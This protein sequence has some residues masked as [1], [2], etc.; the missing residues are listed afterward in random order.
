M[1]K[2]IMFRYSHSSAGKSFHRDKLYYDI[3]F[4][5]AVNLSY[6][7]M[8]VDDWQMIDISTYWYNLGYDIFFINRITSILANNY[9]I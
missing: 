6:E 5:K 3:H 7:M 4:D 8:F 1:N 9:S 2:L